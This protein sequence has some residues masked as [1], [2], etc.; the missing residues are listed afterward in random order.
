MG[1]DVSDDLRNEFESTN[2]P[3][4]VAGSVVNDDAFTKRSD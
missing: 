1:H 2:T 3:V 4:V